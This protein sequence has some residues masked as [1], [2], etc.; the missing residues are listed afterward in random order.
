MV[1]FDWDEWQ[2]GIRHPAGFN[3]DWVKSAAARKGWPPAWLA[4]ATCDILFVDWLAREP[5]PVE[6]GSRDGPVAIGDVS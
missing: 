1:Y 6:A 5:T 3:R 2:E 4:V